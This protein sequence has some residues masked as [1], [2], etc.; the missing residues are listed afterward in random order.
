MKN[1]QAR[2]VDMPLAI[3]SA[4]LLD[5]DGNYTICVN[6]NLD[7]GKRKQ[8]IEHNMQRID[9]DNLENEYTTIE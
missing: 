9:N 5:E 7:S 8:E 1:V 4:I 6:K 3:P 2:G